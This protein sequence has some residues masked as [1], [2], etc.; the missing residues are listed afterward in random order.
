MQSSKTYRRYKE[1]GGTFKG[2]FPGMGTSKEFRVE[3]SSLVDEDDVR[4]SVTENVLL[5][6]F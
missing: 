5:M 1:T 6:F 3:F 4:W 2:V